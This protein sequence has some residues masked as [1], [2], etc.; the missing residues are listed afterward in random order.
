MTEQ[1]IVPDGMTT[2]TA[3]G[4]P[5]KRVKLS[6][7]QRIDNFLFN[8]TPSFMIFLASGWTL[9]LWFKAWQRWTKK[10]PKEWF[11][12]ELPK[13][14]EVITIDHQ[15]HIIKRMLKKQYHINVLFLNYE[16][17]I[18]KNVICLR[19]QYLVAK[20]M[21]DKVDS[22]ISNS[23]SQSGLW[24]CDSTPGALRGVRFTPHEQ[25]DQTERRTSQR[26][27]QPTRRPAKLGS[28]KLGR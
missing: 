11:K 15:H 14:L 23:G 9:L 4:K 22:I 25:V 21:Y 1:T 12:P 13:V 19:G 5:A 28:G 16:W 3:D 24:Y 2:D 6:T 10:H 7:S 26:T 27:A 17:V 20:N 18:V 8:F